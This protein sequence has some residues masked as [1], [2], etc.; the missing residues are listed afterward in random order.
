[1][2]DIE[3]RIV[4]DT[5]TVRAPYSTD[6][7]P[8]ARRLGGRWSPA[9]G[10]WRFDP[11]NETFVRQALMNSYCTDGTVPVETVS[12]RLTGCETV[13]RGPIEYAGRIVAEAASRDGGARLGRGVAILAGSVGSGG[14]SKYWTTHTNDCDASF[15]FH[16]I[17]RECVPDSGH[18]GPWSLVRGDPGSR[19][20]R[21]RSCHSSGGTGS[22]GCAPCR[23]R[24]GAHRRDCLDALQRP[25]ALIAAGRGPAA[26]GNP[27]S[28]S[29]RPGRLI[30]N[31]TAQGGSSDAVSFFHDGPVGPNRRRRGSAAAGGRRSSMAEIGIEMHGDRLNVRSPYN[32]L[33]INGA[34]R[35]GGTW[36]DVCHAWGFDAHDERQVRRLLMRHY[37]TDGIVAPDTV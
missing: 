23:D 20:P 3:V 6:F 25:V 16:D 30:G 1:M 11:R 33:Y 17:P 29:R 18:D 15:L 37:G 22:P 7:P 13:T 8:M 36:S 21:A 5:L 9:G 19:D 4:G 35:F 26:G 28:A 2:I 32:T 14:S 31:C 10:V 24:N 34:R 27:T 12:V